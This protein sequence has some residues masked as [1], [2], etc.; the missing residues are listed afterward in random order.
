[1]KFLIDAQ[2]PRRFCSWLIAAGHDAAHTLDLPQGNRTTDNEILDLAEQ[3]DRIVITKDDDFVQSFLLAGR[4]PKLLL[5]ST[6]N[7]SNTALENLIHTNL[8]T[9][10]EAF[11]AHRFIEIGNESLV[12]HE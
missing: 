4:P 9:I 5:V 10:T 3:Q 6:G 12:I 7:I 8:A 2:L 11:E 1:M